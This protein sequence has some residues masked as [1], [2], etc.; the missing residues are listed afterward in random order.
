MSYPLRDIHSWSAPRPK[1]GT[2]LLEHNFRERDCFFWPCIVSTSLFIG[3]SSVCS[4]SPAGYCMYGLALFAIGLSPTYGLATTPD[5]AIHCN[6]TIKLE[7]ICCTLVTCR[8][9]IVCQLVTT[10]DTAIHC[11]TTIRP[12]SVHSALELLDRRLSTFS[13]NPQLCRL[14]QY[15]NQTRVHP[16]HAGIFQTFTH[17]QCLF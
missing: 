5:L 4:L 13:N 3:E 8:L 12:K 11:N 9:I 14:L 7:S 2:L 10:L 6:T 15:N 16:L 17:L 1:V